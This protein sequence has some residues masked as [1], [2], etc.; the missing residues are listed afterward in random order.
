MLDANPASRATHAVVRSDGRRPRPKEASGAGPRK[1]SSWAAGPPTSADWPSCGPPARTPQLPG[2]DGPKTRQP[3]AKNNH[4]RAPEITKTPCRF[5]PA[6]PVGTASKRS[7]RSSRMSSPVSFLR[8][9][10]S[11][12]KASICECWKRPKTHGAGARKPPGKAHGLVRVV[13]MISAGWPRPEQEGFRL[14]C[15]LY[16]E[17]R[18]SEWDSSREGI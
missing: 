3:H 1:Q 7:R 2:R 5:G 10:S 9:A 15:S 6:G 17:P 12:A 8:T 16:Y 18:Y 11:L 14:R 4:R 13:G